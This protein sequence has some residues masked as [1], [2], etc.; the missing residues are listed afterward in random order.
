MKGSGLRNQISINDTERS[1][2][3]QSHQWIDYDVYINNTRHYEEMRKAMYAYMKIQ[4]ETMYFGYPKLII[5][6]NKNIKIL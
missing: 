4:Q 6:L 3:Q 5:V 1:I 2:L